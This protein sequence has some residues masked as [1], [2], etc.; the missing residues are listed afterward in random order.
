MYS[1]SSNVA[2]LRKRTVFGEGLEMVVHCFVGRGAWG[3]G[4]IK[5]A[6]R[7]GPRAKESA[8]LHRT[9]NTSK[10]CCTP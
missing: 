6:Q 8:R 9:L 10:S 5:A 4:V 7:P 2:F 1:T 3:L